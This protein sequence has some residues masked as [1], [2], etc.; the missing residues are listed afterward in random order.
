MCRG[1]VELTD[2]A[3]NANFHHLGLN[4]M[5]A[6]VLGHRI[7]KEDR[8]R[9]DGWDSPGFSKNTEC[10]AYALDDVW[11][12]HE[13]T[14]RLLP[15]IL[16]FGEHQRPITVRQPKRDR[17]SNVEHAGGAQPPN[18]KRRKRR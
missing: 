5:S 14:M 8:I 7:G 13:V 9:D 10:V 11:A 16:A 2:V 15:A 3:R 12:T 17:S 6:S 18:P 1:L 4:A